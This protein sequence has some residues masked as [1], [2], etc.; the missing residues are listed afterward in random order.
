MS[1]STKN[2]WLISAPKTA[3]DTFSTLNKATQPDGLSTNNKFGVPNELKVGTL[4]SL[5][6]LSDELHKVD[7]FVESVTRK[8][9]VSLFELLDVTGKDTGKDMSSSLSANN[10]S[11]EAYL[12]NFRWDEAKYQTTLPLKALTHIIQAQ[13]AKLDEELKTKSGEYTQLLHSITALERSIGGNLLV[14]DLS[15]VVKEEHVKSTEFLETLFVVVPR[16]SWKDWEQSYEKLT[17]LVVPRSSVRIAEEPEYGLYNVI[18]FKKVVDD[19]KNVARERK[20]ICRE[21]KFDPNQSSIGDKKKLEGERER[22][23]V[24][25]IRWCKTNFSESFIGWIHIKAIRIFV[26]SVLRY[27]LPTNFQAMLVLPQ[28]GKHRKLRQV[29]ANLYSH[30]SKKSVFS[31][32][33]ASEEDDPNAEEF[34]PYVALEIDMD[35]RNKNAF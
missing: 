22:T 33:G 25:L 28:K 15:A 2:Y 7:S 16:Y 26:E 13:V 12:T 34:F 8:V 30:L 20:F 31:K 11:L 32:D 3:D 1:E 27:G 9:A 29:L 6:A 24:S 5:M 18:L 35:F 23:K 19:F 4:D 10:T 14:R 21:Y 17:D